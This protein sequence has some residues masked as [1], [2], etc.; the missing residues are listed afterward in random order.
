MEI[1][2]IFKF[3]LMYLFHVLLVFKIEAIVKK[4]QSVQKN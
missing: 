1:F 2:L 3:I 4:K